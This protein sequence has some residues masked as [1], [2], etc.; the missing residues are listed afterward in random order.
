MSKKFRSSD[1]QE[2]EAQIAFTGSSGLV[3]GSFYGNNIAFNVAG[4]TGTF[5]AVFDGDIT[6]G[7]LH[8]VTHNTAGENTLD[9]GV[10]AGMYSVIWSM[11]LQADGGAGKHIEAAIG[12]DAGGVAGTLTAN[13]AGRNHIHTIGT[14]E[15]AIG[16]TAIL[17]LSANSE[18]GL[19][20]RMSMIIQIS[21]S[22]M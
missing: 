1:V 3:F 5:S 20:L 9:I 19:M 16:G 7:Q 13:I 4:G 15:N 11:S 2:I 21:Q 8:N 17:D 18:V 10:F 22:S 14:N 12:V 6:T